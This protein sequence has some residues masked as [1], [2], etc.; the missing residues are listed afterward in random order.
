[1]SCPE[2]GI[3]I[4]R[5]EDKDLLLRLVNC[6][7]RLPFNLTTVAGLPDDLIAKFRNEDGT[8]LEKKLSLSEIV[9]VD[10]VTGHIKV[11]LTATDTLTLE[12]GEKKSFE[13]EVLD[14]GK[15]RV[16]RFDKLLNILGRV[17]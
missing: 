7:S 3:T 6:P 12:L 15:T 9:I 4:Y 1:M 8:C 5:G 14:A 13:V 11:I 17:C 10:A 16:S 2:S